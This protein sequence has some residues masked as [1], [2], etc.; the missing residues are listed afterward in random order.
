MP[1]IIPREQSH[2]AKR[3]RRCGGDTRGVPVSKAGLLDEDGPDV[4]MNWPVSRAS[5]PRQS[6]VRSLENF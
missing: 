2:S 5:S 3:S 6:V 1:G 4:S